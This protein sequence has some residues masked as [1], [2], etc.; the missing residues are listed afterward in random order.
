[1]SVSG[2][3]GRTLASIGAA[4]AL[5]FA[6]PAHAQTTA[7]GSAGTGPPL[8][9]M[10]VPDAVG[11]DL[12]N[13]RRLGTDSAISIGAADEPAFSL[14]E[15]GGGFG[16][17]PLGGFHYTD[18]THPY[19]S[20]F[21]VL[22]A[23]GAS[24]TF[25]DGT[26]RNLPD[27]MKIQGNSLIEGDGTRWNMTSTGAMSPAADRYLT[28]LVRPD[29][30][31]LTY[32]YSSVPTG[33]IRGRLRSI[34]S[35]AGYQL[36][37]EWEAV[38]STYRLKK[39][40]L[41]NR[42]YTYC[43]PQTGACTGSH[44][45]PTIS[46]ATDS[47]NNTIAT[48]SGLRSVFY[49]PPQQI[50]GGP[51]IYEWTQQITTGAQVS[52]T[53]TIRGSINDWGQTLLYGR[54]IGGLGP[55]SISTAISKVQEASGTWN[56]NW[57]SSCQGF[58]EGTRTDPLNK[59]SSRNG[60]T[61]LDEL[62]R[63]TI[64][65]AI[66]QWGN[67][68]VPGNPI[69]RMT[70]ITHPEGNKVTWDWGAVYGPQNLQRLTVTPKPS[71]GGPALIWTKG[72]APGCDVT[73]LIYC[74]Q[75][76]YEI[77]PRNKRTDYTYDSV[78]GGVLTKTLPADNS[79]LRPQIRYTYD[80][81][82]AKVLN[83]SGVLVIEPPIWK[84]KSTST[85]RTQASCAGTADEVVTSYTYD[86]NLLVATE[87]VRAGD[88]SVSSTVTNSYDHIGNLV[89]VDG[90]ENGPEDTTRYVYDALRRLVAVAGPDPDGPSNPLPVPVTRTTYNGDNQPLLVESGSAANQSD[91]ALAAMT[92]DRKVAT[93]YDGT[94]RK[95]HESQV[96]G[97]VTDEVTQ[98]SYDPAGRL[99]CTAIR[100]NKAAFGALPAS[101][102][103]LG[104]QGSFG[105]DRITRN[106]YDWA[107]QLTK[108]QRAYRITTANGFPATLQQDYVGYE[109]TGNGLVKAVTDANGNRAEMRY[110][111][112][113]R[114][115]CWIFPS[116]TTAGQ[117]GGDCVLGTGDFERY[118]YD[119]N[120]N[121]TTL[122]KRDASTLTFQYD[123]L[124]RMMAKI[125]P[126]RADL[127]PAQ[128]R[129]VYYD[130][131]LRGLRTEARFDSLSGE[132]ISDRYDTF[133][134]V[135]STTST[136]GGA[137][138]T[139]TYKYDARGNRIKVTHPPVIIPT[140]P[141]LGLLTYYFDYQ[142]DHLDR[143]VRITGAN[144][145]VITDWTYNAKGQVER[146][147][148]GN[149]PPSILGYD[150]SS[151]LTS[152]VHDMTV[153]SA[154]LA[155]GLQYNPAN[156]IVSKS[157]TNNAYASNSAYN[158]SRAY[159]TNG[160]NQY[161]QA[162]SRSFD[163][164]GNGNLK[165]VAT[166]LGTTNY[167][168]DVEN[169][170]VSATGL[171]TASLVYDPLG[172]LFQIS[173]GADGTLQFLY[174]GDALI[175]EFNGPQTRAR[176]YVH[177]LRP[178]EPVIWYEMGSNG[179]RLYTDHQGSVIAA[180]QPNT[181]YLAINGYDSWGIPNEANQGRFQYTGQAWLGELGMYYYK[182]RIYSPT[183][184]RFLQTDPIGY[185]DQVNLY[186]YVGNDPVSHIDPNGTS[187]VLTIHA[188][189][190]GSF[191]SHAW[192]TYRQDG[193]KRIRSYGTFNRG[194]GTGRQGLQRNTE[195]SNPSAYVPSASRSLRLTNRQEANLIRYLREKDAEGVNGWDLL[196]NC[197]HFAIDA[198]RAATGENLDP[199]GIN[200]PD[201]LH[202]EI[203]D[204]NGGKT[205]NGTAEWHSTRDRDPS[206]EEA[207]KKR[208]QES[209]ECKYA[210][211]CN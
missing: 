72:Y 31:T 165:S 103:D 199:W 183:L 138:R 193:S 188:Q 141:Q 134:R 110:D 25:G 12:L 162:G 180:A 21:F 185:D 118:E 196:D 161:H 159:Q 168:F 190:G 80:Q 90:A 64:V 26:A 73:T 124:N 20:D 171:S 163:Y 79:G 58:S 51:S 93:I 202:D 52:R 65:T 142:Y 160:L 167:V 8:P 45:W 81:Y 210:G 109:Y 9:E 121:R 6:S 114:R 35:G 18:G 36:N 112:H 62:S 43:D 156:Q 1:M 147:G 55:C 17:T 70:S 46:W 3:L 158:V 148:R 47:S 27:G 113:D 39:V 102:C 201:R 75:P 104:A 92:V 204:Q 126:P 61:F 111:G 28:T 44:A 125:V 15:G 130:Y 74:N 22:G 197:S 87:T 157:S 175:A 10:V 207:D 95:T 56:Y 132:G 48:T 172:R 16:G 83:A 32:S 206:A 200:T 119:E 77:D 40:T 181:S 120:G 176:A 91:S 173:G 186:A 169:R 189:R 209:F 122:R 41:T 108:V 54:P 63:T 2:L 182:A 191:N 153:D 24:N 184:G 164:D 19:M 170:L 194:T 129:D 154:D 127:T 137:S 30:E 57:Q 68:A 66:D 88:N 85:C 82:S 123:G 198:W 139:I 67:N 96:G 208:R 34:R 135:A 128:T 144:S 23:R 140:H 187:G 107:G 150:N 14:T 89:S 117:L 145:A 94:G 29:G 116:K 105:P 177:G 100:M 192:I 99:D 60:G 4:F 155:L 146:I 97:T 98:F 38:G 174:D 49:G 11:I 53:Y 71:L 37:V 76:L 106:Q 133:G 143:P 86:D 101:A 5:G 84:L 59:T 42:R 131:D 151:R 203:V 149:F 69:T 166:P 13:G 205:S 115:S 33:N 152:I 78:H 136:M 7:G 211:V 195:L 179:R 50:Q 178:N